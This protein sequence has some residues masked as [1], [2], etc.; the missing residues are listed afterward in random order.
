MIKFLRS[1]N[2]GHLRFLDFK[3]VEIIEK[4]VARTTL[5]D[6]FQAQSLIFRQEIFGN[7][8]LK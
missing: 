1:L 8:Y 2:E 6:L 7:R 5:C 3:K 4:T